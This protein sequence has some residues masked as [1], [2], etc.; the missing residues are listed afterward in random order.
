MRSVIW[1]P[2]FLRS[3]G[4][5]LTAVAAAIALGSTVT[6]AQKA[7]AGQPQVTFTK[8]IAPILQRSCITCHRP[9]E[10][11]PM[12]LLTYEDARPWA[13]SIKARVAAREMPPWHIDRNI[14]IQKF[15]D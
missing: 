2:R 8:D 15:K 1:N 6:T 3:A 12:A 5:G 9:G 14:G 10:M 4:V 13:K 7:P 11:A